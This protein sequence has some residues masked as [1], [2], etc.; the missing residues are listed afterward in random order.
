[1]QGASKNGSAGRALLAGVTLMLAIGQA[2][3]CPAQESKKIVGVLEFQNQAGITAYEIG[4]VT[5]MLRIAAR[6][7]LPEK[8]FVVM[9]RENLVKLLPPGQALER[10]GE[11]GCE[12]EVGRQIGADYIVA[13]EVGRFG[14]SLQV[15]MKLYNTR[16]GDL[17]AGQIAEAKDLDGLKEP[18][19]TKAAALFA[20][21]SGAQPATAPL[22]APAQRR[23]GGPYPMNPYKLWGHVTFWTGLGLAGMGSMFYALAPS[24]QSGSGPA[25]GGTLS[26]LSTLK[27]QQDMYRKFAYSGW[28]TG[29]VLVV[30]G[31]ILWIVSPGDEAWANRQKVSLVPFFN[32][33]GGGAAVVGSW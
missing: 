28:A 15:K 7:R 1:M 23:D 24:D 10:C 31:T 11:G 9:T 2:L 17:V 14:S 3:P 19:G 33:R 26:T 22:P 25:T 13:G 16:S 12:V 5:D 29:G 32:E 27:D 30:T 6:E 21:L 4:A 20:K 18:I 8:G